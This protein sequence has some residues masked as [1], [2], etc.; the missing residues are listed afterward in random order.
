M[1]M[2][3]WTSILTLHFQCYRIKCILKSQAVEI[4]RIHIFGTIYLNSSLPAAFLFLNYLLVLKYKRTGN[5]AELCELM[6]RQIYGHHN[7]VCWKICLLYTICLYVICISF[8]S[9]THR[10]VCYIFG[11]LKV[12]KRR[13]FPSEIKSSFNWWVFNSIWIIG[14]KDQELECITRKRITP[15]KNG[16]WKMTCMGKTVRNDNFWAYF[17]LSWRRFLTVKNE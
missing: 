7:T 5:W 3:L 11:F 14:T 9:S 12:T 10:I 16:L 6:F 4:L 1:W 15:K 2:K 17:Y 13:K 8:H